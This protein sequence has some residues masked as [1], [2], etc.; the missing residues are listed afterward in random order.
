MR[1]RAIKL[2]LR[3][4][5]RTKNRRSVREQFPQYRFGKGT[6][7]RHLDVHDWRQG[8]TLEI[9]AFCS[10]ANSV[11]I[12]L[13]GDHRSDLVTTFP[14]DTLWKSDQPLTPHQSTKGGVRIGNDVWI[15]REAV[16]M[17]G[18]TIGDGAVVGAHAVV[19]K[20]VAPYAIVVGNP[21]REIRKR[22]DDETIRELLEIRWWDL[23][24]A[25]ISQLL[26]L[27][28]NTDVAALI[29]AVKQYR[30]TEH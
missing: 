24:D 2:L 21:A 17:A 13:G 1:F 20:N 23:D 28:M 15:G 16:I 19:G 27:L 8:S 25:V 12:F 3:R 7:A 4:I 14:F 22:F 10:L 5:Y 29:K 30:A 6:Y 11:Q 26:P 18:V 9:G